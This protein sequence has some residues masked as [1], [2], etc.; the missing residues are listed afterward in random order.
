[1]RQNGEPK[2]EAKSKS[3][4][5]DD[6]GPTAD[7]HGRHAGESCGEFERGA[8]KETGKTNDPTKRGRLEDTRYQWELWVATRLQRS[9]L[10]FFL[11]SE[12]HAHAYLERDHEVSLRRGSKGSKGGDKATSQ[13]AHRNWRASIS[14]RS[15]RESTLKSGR[16]RTPGE[17]N[18]R[19]RIAEHA[20]AKSGTNP[21]EKES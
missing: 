20:V 8:T 2:D 18:S 16:K 15:G 5:S 14:P 12:G 10:A 11:P 17:D 7:E 21:L 3:G 4:P 9:T 19:T 13:T 1:M 6:L